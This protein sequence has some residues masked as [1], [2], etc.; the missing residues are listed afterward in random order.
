MTSLEATAGPEHYSTVSQVYNYSGIG[1]DSSTTTTDSGN[2]TS[3]STVEP[4][5]IAQPEFCK[6]ILYEQIGPIRLVRPICQF[7]HAT[8]DF[9][10][11][12]TFTRIRIWD[13]IILIPNLLF[14]LFLIYRARDARQRLRSSRSS[15]IFATFYL[16]VVVSVIMSIVRCLISMAVNSSSSAGGQTDRIFWV[17]VRFFLLS[18]EISVLVFGLAFGHL[19][20]RTST[21]RVL[22]VTCFLALAYSLC[23]GTLEVIDPDEKFYVQERN[24]TLFSHGQ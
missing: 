23:Q 11:L 16:L 21:N 15:P 17:L 13:W 2:Y 8:C 14:L 3:T 18:T 10:W 12:L 4:D 22:V 19:D 20:S 5:I 7:V 24:V 6:W 9:S 1:N